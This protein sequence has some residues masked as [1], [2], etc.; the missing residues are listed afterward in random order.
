MLDAFD[1]PEPQVLEIEKVAEHFARFVRDDDAV[2]LR[3]CQQTRCKVGRVADH[4][5]F[6]CVARADQVAN[7]NEA[8]R[9]ADARLQG[10]GGFDRA[11]SWDEFECGADGPLDVILVCLRISEIDQHAISAEPGDEAV[12]GANDLRHRFLICADDRA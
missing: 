10:L 3:E 11:D 4:V 7:H 5:A 9:N 6:A 8:G 2:G 1:V 12:V